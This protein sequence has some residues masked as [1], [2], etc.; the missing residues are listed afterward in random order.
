M[1]DLVTRCMAKD[2]EERIGS[3]DEVLAVLKRIT[4][5]GMSVTGEYRAL[6]V[7]AS[8][9]YSR[10]EPTPGPSQRLE[11]LGTLKA[12]SPDSMAPAPAS[13]TPSASASISG[14]APRPSVTPMLDGAGGGAVTVRGS[15]PPPDFRRGNRKNVLLACAGLCAVAGIAAL[16]FR[17]PPSTVSVAQTT[18]PAS[19]AAN[20]P[21]P[22]PEAPPTPPPVT[23]PAPPPV[24]TTLSVHV[25]TDPPGASV[26]ENG[27]ELCAATPCDLGLSADP[28]KE[29]KVVIARAGFRP[30]TR[31]VHGGDAQV[32]V[33]LVSARASTGPARAATPKPG[34]PGNGT[35]TGFKDIPY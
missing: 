14:L 33:T 22:A 29:H 4:S 11:S 28:T 3:M 8:G 7:S 13:D 26:K 20:A 9:P 6:G 32:A 34:E 17:S 1:E 30:E 21:A 15:V 16:A 23:A 24:A 12:A 25:V 10:A 19:P 27:Q 2:P 35:P 31:V 5:P 18:L